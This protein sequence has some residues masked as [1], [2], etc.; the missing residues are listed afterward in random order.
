[1]AGHWL[2]HARMRFDELADTA[3]PFRDL[4]R[5]QVA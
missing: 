2:E 1:M 4:V 3:G 5:R